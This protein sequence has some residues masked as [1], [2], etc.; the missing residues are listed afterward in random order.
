MAAV[1]TVIKTLAF[2]LP[3]VFWG[4][5]LIKLNEFQYHLFPPGFFT[6][7]SSS[8][9]VNLSIFPRSKGSR[10]ASVVKARS[11][12]VFHSTLFLFFYPKLLKHE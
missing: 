11:S 7:H 4:L 10:A 12:D 9:Q 3:I 8:T 1:E 2:L 6:F 5:L